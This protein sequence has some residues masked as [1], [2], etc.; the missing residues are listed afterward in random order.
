MK[1]WGLDIDDKCEVLS[2]TKL[3]LKP[4]DSVKELKVLQNLMRGLD[5]IR[6]LNDGQEMAPMQIS[7]SSEDVVRDYLTKV[8]ARWHYA[9]VTARDDSVL[10]GGQHALR[11]APLD[12]V[13][14]HPVV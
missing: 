12:V 5:L 10:A 14:T 9:L 2:W 7:K 13:M 4:K 8:L 3:E 6:K 1:N 11:I